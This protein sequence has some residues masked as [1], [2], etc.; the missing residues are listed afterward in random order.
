MHDVDE[1]LD[2]VDGSLR[3]DAVSQVEDVARASGCL[4]ENRARTF[5]GDFAGSAKQKRVDVA[6]DGVIVTNA[7]PGIVERNAPIDTDDGTA[8]ITLR[9]EERGG[10]GAEVNDGHAGCFEVAED[11]ADVR[12]DV[13]AIVF[14]RK[15]A[16]PGIEELNGLHA[17]FDLSAKEAPNDLGDLAHE[18]GEKRGVAPHQLFGVKVIRGPSAF[19][20][21]A[22]D[23]ERRAGKTDERGFSVE[24]TTDQA[25]GLKYV[26]E[27][28]FGVDDA[29]FFDGFTRAYGLVN[30]GSFA[31]GKGER[32]AHGLEREE[33]V[34][35][36]D[37]GVH[38]ETKGL[39]RDLEGELGSAAQ[40][41]ERV[42]FAKC[43]VL[44]HVSACLAHEPHGGD[45][46][47]FA[48]ASAQKPI[49]HGRNS[50]LYGRWEQRGIGG[51]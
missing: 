25:D 45:V 43:A 19:D 34:G 29:E 42:F 39:Q 10:V 48:A 2:V 24:F 47:F 13:L 27:A 32:R 35:E 21:I 23:G 26:V 8:G 46:C 11:V 14:G 33:D 9:F 18:L 36:E 3:N 41:E 44:G 7:F 16:G 28:F 40:F 22:G 1:R 37:G 17:G 6:L 15:S 12:R 50:D 4:V 38:A 30:D 31:F 5:G 51:E 49:E 20:E